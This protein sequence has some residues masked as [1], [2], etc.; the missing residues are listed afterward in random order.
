MRASWFLAAMGAAFL[1]A[2]PALAHDDWL[3]QDAQVGE[4]PRLFREPGWPNVGIAV[5]LLLIVISLIIID[6]RRKRGAP[7]MIVTELS[8]W[9]PT[10]VGAA[11][12][13]A[14]IDAALGRTLFSP[15][16]FVPDGTVGTWAIGFEIGAAVL[17]ATG[18]F[19]RFGA[20][21]MLALYVFAA[22]WNKGAALESLVIPGLASFLIVWGRGRLSL[23]S[24]FGRIFYAMDSEHARPFATTVLRVFVG[25]TL[26]AL[27]VTKLV[28]PDLGLRVLDVFPD[29]NPYRLVSAV[30]P[31]VTREWYLFLFAMLEGTLG[32]L[33]AAG[34]F[35]RPLALVA[36]LCFLASP[37]MFGSNELVF[38]LPLLAAF[39]ALF[40]LGRDKTD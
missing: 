14:M 32:L 9:M 38:H 19:A 6:R 24:V 39:V 23:G 5:A 8:M 7:L 4:I 22:A 26:V 21:V 28:R 40:V 15:D 10:V 18:L 36:F 16:L 11:A 35:I 17:I 3:V 37:L 29:A 30:L 13:Y 2:A 1:V 12:A 25:A 31:F 34:A 27:A 20:I 33:I